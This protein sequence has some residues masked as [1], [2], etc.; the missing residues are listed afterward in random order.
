MRDATWY[1]WQ[2]TR[3]LLALHVQP[4]AAGAGCAG[5][6]GDRLKIRLRAAPSDGRAN[7]ELLTWLAAEFGVRRNQVALTAGAAHR[8]KRVEVDSP[9]AVPAWFTALGGTAPGV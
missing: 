2:G 8:D 5:L 4:R 9:S 3:L 6:H 1:A 7:A